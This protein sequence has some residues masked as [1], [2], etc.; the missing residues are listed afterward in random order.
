MISNFGGQLLSRKPNN[1]APV[2][3]FPTQI[4]IF[5]IWHA[6]I[7]LNLQVAM[8]PAVISQINDTKFCV[9]CQLFSTSYFSKQ[10]CLTIYTQTRN[11]LL[12][13]AAWF[14]KS[15]RLK[16]QAL[17][18]LMYSCCKTEELLHSDIKGEISRNFKHSNHL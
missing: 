2:H 13:R 18:P 8:V 6:I 14:F 16:F 5:C 1:V 3:L 15:S 11:T 4:W 17:I 7:V 10:T 9:L 12:T